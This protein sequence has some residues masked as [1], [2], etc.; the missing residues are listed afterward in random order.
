MVKNNNNAVYGIY[1]SLED[2]VVVISGG[3]AGIGAAMVNAF[4][5]QG[6]KVAFLDIDTK[7]PLH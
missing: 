2:R 5:E 4:S 7:E 1:P 3:S 6:S